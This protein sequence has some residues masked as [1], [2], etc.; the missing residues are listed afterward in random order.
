MAESSSYLQPSIPRF[1]GHY[2]HWSMLME[3]LLRSKEYWNLIEDGVFVAPAGASQE[4]IQRAHESKLNDLKAKNFLFQ[5][6]DRSI[7]ETILARG[8]AKEIWDSMRQKYQGSTKV[9]RAQL[10]AL[11]KDFETLN[12]KIGESIEEYFSRTLCI[13]NKMSSHGETVTQS[14]IVEKILRS[15]TS[16][17]NY[18]ACS[19]EESNDTTTMTVDELQSSLLVQEQRMR[20]QKDEQEQI[21]KVSN[22]GRGY[23]GG[24]GEGSYSR[25]R[26]RARGRGGRGASINKESVE[27]YKCHKLGHYQADCPSWE[28]DHANYAQFDETKEI[29][30]MA[31]ETAVNNS[32]ESD[33]KL[34]LW[35]LDSGCSN[36]MVGNKNWLF[37]FDDTFKDSVKL[38]DD[39]KMAVEGKGNLKLYIKGF[40]QTLTSVY[41][42]PGLKNNLL[43]IGQLQQK[44]LTIIFKDDACKVFHDE[45][46][47][48]MATTMTF[49]RMFVIKAPVIVPQ[50]MKISGAD[51]STLWHQRYGH[52][53][54]KGMNILTQKQMVIGLPKLK[55]SN[56][57]CTNCMKGKQQKQSAPKKSSWR[58]S[59]KLELVH[60]DICGPISPESNGK[61]RYFITFTDDMSR[62]TWIYFM[63]EK[64][65]A[66]TMFKKFKA[67]V[68][69]ECKQAIQ[70][71]RTDRGGEYTSSVFNEFCDSH[72]IRRQLTAAY[73]PHQNGVSERKNR[74]IMN[75]VRCMI[76]EK[77]VPKSFWPEAV[78][79]AAHILNRSPTF[80]V[81]D[82]TPEEAWSGIK[83][84]V[85]HFKVFGCIAYVH[86]PDNLRKKL[87]DKSTVCIHLG[88]SEE[89]KAY[90]LYD[91][92]KRRIVVSK[93][94]KH[95]WLIYLPTL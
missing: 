86:V 64:S 12:M 49:N 47:L 5:A 33:D 9:K 88:L 13:A 23:N 51:D 59:T 57:K 24:R 42:L 52:L 20:S 3:N 75:M 14:M 22:G 25:G 60:S 63:Y 90:K 54:F 15:L 44:N 27:C 16:R 11:R 95:A 41:Y 32:I 35:F 87:D 85:S 21:L 92:V 84:S 39:S 8:T 81:K 53:S 40:V 38:G 72:G 36:H 65:E 1:D 80:A 62:K 67:L 10:Q 69:N 50:C 79:W 91:P 61:K 48:I 78:N 93:D 19:I 31:Q 6:I 2:D 66:L 82:V 58:A 37:D 77:N 76:S 71:L 89:S 34:E 4:Q 28:E 68:E 17:F 43:S 73:T 70:C 26:G 94:V 18:V 7:L 29:L 46:G 55:E 30:L 56:E 45:K 83:P 74:T